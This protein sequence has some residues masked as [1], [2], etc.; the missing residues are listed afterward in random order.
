MSLL[1][2]IQF[3]MSFADPRDNFAR[4]LKLAEQAI[5]QKA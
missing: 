4:A 2:A 3:D 1:A 5:N